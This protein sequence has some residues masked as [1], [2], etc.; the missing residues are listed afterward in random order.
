[1]LAPAKIS[2]YTILLLEPAAE[3]LAALRATLE[4]ARHTVHVARSGAEA[5][6]LLAAGELL[7]DLVL[8]ALSLPDRQGLSWL[9]QACP[10]L[11]RTPFL[12]LA[13]RDEAGDL[14][15]APLGSDDYLVEPFEARDVLARI[16]RI[17]A[18]NCFQANSYQ[19]TSPEAFASGFEPLYELP[20][21]RPSRLRTEASDSTLWL[22]LRESASPDSAAEPVSGLFALLGESRPLEERRARRLAGML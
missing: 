8:S 11:A 15:A 7:P 14:P 5:L 4:A 18:R 20:A 2:D 16:R 22:R 1:M 21:A 10:A 13:R 12:F 3:T 6:E 9:R 19:P 17:M